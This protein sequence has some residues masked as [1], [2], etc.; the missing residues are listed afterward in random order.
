[1]KLT[2]TPLGNRPPLEIENKTKLKVLSLM[3]GAV[4]R[5]LMGLILMLA[6]QKTLAQA[7]Y[8][9]NVGSG[10]WTTP[11]NWNPAR[12][13]VATTDIL[14][15]NNSA[16]GATQTATGVPTQ[17][18][19][20]LIIGGGV[21]AHLQASGPA[22]LSLASDG[23]ATDELSIA[24]GSSLISEGNTGQLFIVYSGTGSTGNIAGTLGVNSTLVA[25]PN[26]LRKRAP[27][28]RPLK[29]QKSVDY[30]IPG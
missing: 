2:S 1:M 4:T 24:S 12:N 3:V 18:I 21:T 22:N 13:V 14:Q 6:T 15:F 10:L 17:T 20:R 23:S 29:D 25:V 8:T 26:T 16:V 27:E 28:R 7:T 11:S 19:R 30:L 9:W 5:C